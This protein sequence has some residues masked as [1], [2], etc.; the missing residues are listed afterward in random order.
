MLA[1]RAIPQDSHIGTG[2]DGRTGARAVGR[3]VGT[4]VRRALEEV[5]LQRVVRR[6]SRLGVVVQHA[7]DEVL[8]LEVVRGGVARLAGAT[9]ARSSRLHSED[10]V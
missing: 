4:L 8:E 10:V 2:G 9:T 7:Q 5:V 3:R 1:V 6:D